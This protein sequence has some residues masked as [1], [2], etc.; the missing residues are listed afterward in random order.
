MIQPPLIHPPVCP[1]RKGWEEAFAE[2]ASQ[3]DDTL[4][5]DVNTTTWDQIEWEW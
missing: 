5:D 3:Q 1:A 2:M 4:L